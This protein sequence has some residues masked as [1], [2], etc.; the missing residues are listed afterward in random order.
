MSDDALK[1]VQDAI[2][3][4]VRDLEQAIK[5]RDARIKNLERMVEKMR[6]NY[7]GVIE[8]CQHLKKKFEDMHENEWWPEISGWNDEEN[9]LWG[10]KRRDDE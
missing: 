9:E 1:F 7:K 2:D 3:S 8:Q 10:T 5:N 6:I 4:K